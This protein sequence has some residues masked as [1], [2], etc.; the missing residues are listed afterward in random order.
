MGDDVWEAFR[1]TRVRITVGGTVVD[2]APRSDDTPGSFLPGASGP[3]HIL[4]AENPMGR[5][6]PPEANAAANARLAAELAGTG[7][8]EVWPATGYG[9]GAIDDPDTWS[10]A[11]FAVEGLDDAA[12]LD[13]ARRHHQRAIFAWRN[14][15]GGFRLVACDGSADEAR[16]WV[17]TVVS[18]DPDRIRDG[19][20]SARLDTCAC[21]PPTCTSVTRTSSGTATV[22]TGRWRR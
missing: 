20:A 7:L 3:I 21:S 1:H 12:A 10:E 9:G 13:I 5:A 11:G 4:T 16:G 19:A 14:E 15:P 2:I 6:A 8:V 17:T 18:I 22:P